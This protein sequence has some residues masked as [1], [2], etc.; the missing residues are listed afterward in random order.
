MAI[1]VER[2][3]EFMAKGLNYGYG[4]WRLH[5]MPGRRLQSLY[6]MAIFRSEKRVT[7]I[8]HFWKSLEQY[9]DHPDITD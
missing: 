2:L 3:W 9:S 6:F 5:T 8:L 1:Q 4:L 7:A